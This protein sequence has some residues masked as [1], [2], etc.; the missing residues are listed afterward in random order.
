MNIQQTALED[1]QVQLNVEVEN[2]TFEGARRR[3]ARAISKRV[4]VPGFRPGKAPF[5]VIEKQVG[6]AAIEEEAIDLLLEDVYPQVLEESGVQPWGPGSLEKVDEEKDKRLFQFRVPLSPEVK[7]GDYSALRVPFKTKEVTK[8]DVDGVLQNLREEH[9]VLEPVE[10]PVEEG[11]MAY[12]LLSGERANPDKEGKTALIKENT[13]P[14]VV[15]KKDADTATEWPFPGFSQ[16]LVG[17][18][19]EEEQE[20][21]HTFAEDSEFEDL[22]GEAAVFKVKVSE[23]KDRILPELTDEFA[24][25]LGEYEDLKALTAEV[26]E[27]LKSNFEQQQSDEYENEI[28]GKIIDLSE[29]NYPPQMLEHEIEHYIEDL[30]PQFAQQG[31][32]L[33]TYLKSRN[34]ELSDLQEEVQPT[35]IERVK[36]SLVLMEVSRAE[37]IEVT[38]EK[39]Q[40]LVTERVGRLQQ[41]MGEDE[42]ANALSGDA[43]QGLVSRTM[44]E[45]VINRTLARLKSI[46]K[47][48]ADKADAKEEME[49]DEQV[50]AKAPP[51]QAK[52][53][54]KKKAPAKSP[55]KK[56]SKPQ[57][58]KDEGA[59]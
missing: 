44:T 56:K 10:R 43:L 59:K 27:S 34:M 7:L 38:E 5:N 2:E 15:E 41:L 36:K 54:P 9:A 3:A 30:G 16:K 37:E 57:A 23:I 22:R 46:A 35:V 47:G 45:E 18:K 26:K 53:S 13:Y 14:V 48:E 32:T 24:K 6:S 58:K 49:A 17:L 20:F 33:D 12:V 1:H 4:K 52:P 31:L 19:P 28:V 29:I 8:K 55:P 21:T 11:D 42:A 40:E 25:S 39:I 50:E 51:K